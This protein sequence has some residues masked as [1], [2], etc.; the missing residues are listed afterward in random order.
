M[1]RVAVTHKNLT[2][3]EATEA[4][5]REPVPPGKY[6]AVIMNVSAGSTK[7]TTPLSKISVEFQIVHMIMEDG[8]KEETHAS[9][10]VYQDFILEDD[11][12]MPDLSEQR[13]YELRMLLDACDV[14]FD[15]EG[16]DTDHLK[17]KAVHITVRHREGNKVDDDGNK[18]IFTNVVK[19]DSA[20]EIAAS[21]LV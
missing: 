9:R 10:R 12:S 2:S 6:A 14:T 20:E 1:A 8:E 18:R 13:R 5:K 11:P 3:E 19:V 4:P 15:D 17:E 7:H 16:F 21:D